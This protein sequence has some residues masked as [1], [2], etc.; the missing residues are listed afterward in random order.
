MLK[1]VRIY[2]SVLLAIGLLLVT[3]LPAFAA[4][5]GFV[6]KDGSDIHYEYGYSELQSSYVDK[7]LGDASPLYDHF[8]SGKSTVSLLD[9]V[10]GYVDYL[11]VQSAFVDAQ[12]EGNA[13]DANN[14]TE[15]LAKAFTMPNSFKKVVVVDGNI[16]EQDVNISQAAKF[17]DASITVG[18][19]PLSIVLDT[20]GLNG[21]LDLSTALATD[22]VT[23]GSV[24]SNKDAILTLTSVKAA[25]GTDKLSLLTAAGCPTTQAL[26]ANTATSLN[27]ITYLGSLDSQGDG[28]SLEI[29]R[30]AFGNSVEI[31]GTLGSSTVQLAITLQ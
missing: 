22:V 25:D 15:T 4:I 30:T 27:L 11:D 23:E 16:V 17:N 19:V 24:T 9:T 29:L 7:Q 8:S 10:K 12:L 31:N 20:A 6:A 2:F 26:T 14:Y 1:K 5:S 3:S 21:T 18:G 28:V 13:F